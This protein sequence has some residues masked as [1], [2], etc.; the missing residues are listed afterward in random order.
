MKNTEFS[1]CDTV[2]PGVNLKTRPHLQTYLQNRNLKHLTVRSVSG[3]PFH[4][5][6]YVLEDNTKTDNKH[7]VFHCRM[8]A[9]ASRQEPK[10]C[11]YERRNDILGCV[12]EFPDTI[13]RL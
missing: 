13:R 3:T 7:R 11:S 4:T 12:L 1:L 2:K 8:E 5:S 9:S 10:V 6:R